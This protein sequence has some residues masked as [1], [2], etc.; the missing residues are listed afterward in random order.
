M[1][2]AAAN[3]AGKEGRMSF[4]GGSFVCDQFGRVL[5]RA[6][7]REQVLLATCD[8]SLGRQVEEGWGF[9]RNRKP[10]TYRKLTT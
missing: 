1:I 6:D 8:L 3:R 10:A 5:A 9:L 4:W 2:V 7:E